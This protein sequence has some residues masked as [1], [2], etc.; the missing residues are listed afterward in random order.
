MEQRDILKKLED[1]STLIND[2]KIKLDID[3]KKNRISELELISNDS[4]FWN[5]MEN[6]KNI[7][8]EV[9]VMEEF[10]NSKR[11]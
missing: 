6:A 9:G 1:Y 8:S 2:I 5:D 10:H 4:S 3:N 7:L 11:K